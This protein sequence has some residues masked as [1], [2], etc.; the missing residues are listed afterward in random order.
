MF[1]KS[2]WLI[3]VRVRV[4]F[5]VKP[6]VMQNNEIYEKVYKIMKYFEMNTKVCKYNQ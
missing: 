3:P 2:W 1:K 5:E 6:F 4:K